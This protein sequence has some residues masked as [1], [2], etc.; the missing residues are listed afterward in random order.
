M[1]FVLTVLIPWA[2]Q[3]KEKR[4]VRLRTQRRIIHS[5]RER[6][7]GY[8]NIGVGGFGCGHI[9]ETLLIMLLSKSILTTLPV[10][11][12]CQFDNWTI[13][14]K[15]LKKFRKLRIMQPRTGQRG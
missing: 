11:N 15:P 10:G 6:K 12:K 4:R 8:H 9:A 2:F 7:R 14:V 3:I 1:V 13:A 5:P